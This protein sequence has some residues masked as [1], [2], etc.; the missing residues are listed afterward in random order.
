METCIHDFSDH[1]NKAKQHDDH[2]HFVSFITFLLLCFFSLSILFIT[3][4]LSLMFFTGS[5]TVLH[6]PVLLFS[7][8]SFSF[9]LVPQVYSSVQFSSW[10]FESLP[11]L[12]THSVSLSST[13]TYQINPPHPLKSIPSAS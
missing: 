6:P 10:S 7:P 1:P 9:S 2:I 8:T 5:P 3:P 12:H 11:L 13:I 4:F